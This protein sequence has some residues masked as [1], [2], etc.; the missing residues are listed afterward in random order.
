MIVP[1]ADDPWNSRVILKP[2]HPHTFR[3]VAPGVSYGAI[4]ELLTFEMDAKGKVARVRTP[5]FYWLP[6]Q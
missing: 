1:E 3:M 6:I 2:L 5:N 4:G